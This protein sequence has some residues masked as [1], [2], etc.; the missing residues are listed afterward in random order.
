MFEY[1]EEYCSGD[2]REGGEKPGVIET[3]TN[4]A[5]EGWELISVIPVVSGIGRSHFTAFFKRNVIAQRKKW[6][7]VK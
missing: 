1:R 2:H 3:A 6:R 4:L 5:K 7:L